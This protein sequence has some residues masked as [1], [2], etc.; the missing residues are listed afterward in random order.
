MSVLVLNADYT[1][2]SVCTTERAFLLMYL[3]KAD[4]ITAAEDKMLRTVQTSYPFPSVIKIKQYIHVPYKSVVLTRQNV[5]RRDNY[6]CQYCGATKDLTLDHLIPKSK[7]GRSSWV[8]LV[9][10]CKRCNS[11]KGDFTPEEAG[12]Q[13]KRKPIRPSYITFLRISSK[14]VNDDW[15]P[16]L[17]R[18][19]SA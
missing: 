11:L 5:F 4:I 17:E 14:Y 8:N 3:Q 15:I 6:C 12:L 7:G 2:L 10:A 13:L 9:T 16:F 19:A 18:K 1:P